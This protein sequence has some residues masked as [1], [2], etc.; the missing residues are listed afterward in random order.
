MGGDLV[1]TVTAGSGMIEGGKE[2]APGKG[3]AFHR[4]CHVFLIPVLL[5]FALGP[6]RAAQ[7]VS[8]STSVLPYSSVSFI[9]ICLFSRLCLVQIEAIIG[10][11]QRIDTCER[12]NIEAITLVLVHL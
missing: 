6:P 9:L 7:T 8:R 10:E 2:G 1:D 5:L 12:T 4:Q 3:S 11:Q